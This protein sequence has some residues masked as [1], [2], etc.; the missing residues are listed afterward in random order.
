MIKPLSA[1]R[2][3]HTSIQNTVTTPETMNLPTNTGVVTLDAVVLAAP[4]TGLSGAALLH[5]PIHVHQSRIDAPPTPVTAFDL[6][7]E[8]R[9]KH[10]VGRDHATNDD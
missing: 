6:D 10:G 4:W 2:S 5:A 3:K 7:D 1:M 9:Q 8:V